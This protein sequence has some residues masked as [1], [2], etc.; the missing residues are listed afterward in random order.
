MDK[1]NISD[2]IDEYNKEG[3]TSYKKDLL[4]EKA[5]AKLDSRKFFADNVRVSDFYKSAHGGYM[6]MIDS[7][8]PATYIGGPDVM[9]KFDEEP[10]EFILNLNRH[11]VVNIIGD[12]EGIE[13][14]LIVLIN[15]EVELVADE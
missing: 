9:C 10:E 5:T 15:C 12:F 6:L 3:I 14:G 1:T 2:F 7:P 11:D 8:K 13:L 4:I